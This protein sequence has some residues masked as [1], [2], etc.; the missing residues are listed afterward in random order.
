MY[1]RFR[2]FYAIFP[3]LTRYLFIGRWQAED[4]SYWLVENPTEFVNIFDQ[5]HRAKTVLDRI[6]DL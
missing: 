5:R 2:Y 6:H 3:L 4:K 1:T